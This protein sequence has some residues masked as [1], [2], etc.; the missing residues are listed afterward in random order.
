MAEVTDLAGETSQ[1]QT[2]A[3]DAAA[4]PRRAA[5]LD[6]V[7][8][9]ELPGQPAISPDG[10]R[11]IYVLRTADSGADAE[12]SSL[13]QVPAGGG[14]PARLTRGPADTAPA[15][16]P[17]GSQVAFLRGGDAPAQVW[18]LPA[19]AGE[20][21]QLTELP[22]GAGAPR[23]SPDGS[24]IAFTAPTAPGA[25][26]TGQENKTAPAVIDRLGYKADGAGL[27]AGLRSHLHVADVATGQVRQVTSGDWHAGQ[28]EWSPDGRQ[29]AFAA[30]R[31]EDWDLSLTSAAYVVDA[32]AAGAEPRL[33]GDSSGTVGSVTWE[34]SGEALLV[35][36]GEARAG[37]ARLR[38]VPLDGAEAA[39]LATDLDRNVMPGA[40]GYPGGQPAFTG[41]GQTILFCARNRGCTSLYATTVSG[42][43]AA[44]V[45]A[46]PGQVVAGLSVAPGAGRAAVVLAGPASFGE[47]AV[48]D[49]PAG[50]GQ[51]QDGAGLRVLTGHTRRALPD[52]RLLEATER[53]FTI[54]D[55][56]RVHGWLL[57]D[58][59]APLPA[60]LLLD[61]HGGPHNA[62]NPAADHGHLYQQVLAA[63]GFAVLTV[64]PRGSDGYGE[65]FY[66]AAVGAWGHGDERDFLEPVD[67]L[68]AEG[69][70]DPYRLAVTGYSY[71]G[72]MTCHLTTRTTRFSAAVAGGAVCDLASMAGTSDVGHGLA[73]TEL[74][75][76][77]QQ[78]RDQ[79]A[80]QSPIERAGQVT[81]PTLLLHG[82]DDDRCPRGQAEQWFTA[83]RERRVPTRLVLYP[84]A[85]HLFILEGRP[86]HRA[87]YGRRL[88]GWVCEHTQPRQ[89]ARAAAPDG[90][91]VPV[92]LDQAHWAERLSLLAERHSVPGAVL[93]ILRM[94]PG[95]GDEQVLAASGVLSTATGVEVTT[96]SLF[97]IGSIT[98]VWTATL[99]M[100]F[101]DEG[102][103]DLDAPLEAVLPGL[104]LPGTGLARRLTVRHLLTHTSGIDGDL[105]ADTGRGDDCVQKYVALLADA[106]INHPPGATLSYCNSGY[107]LAGRIAEVLGGASWD[108]VLRKRLCVPLGLTRT[109]T[110][111]EEALLGRAAVGHVSEDG[112]APHPAPVWVLPRSAGPAGLICTT[113]ADVLGFARLHLAGGRAPDGT[114]LLSPGAAEAMQA[115]QADM[116][117]P[118][119]LGDSWGLGWIRFGWDGHRLA[120]HDGGTIGQ[121]AYLRLLPGQGLAVTLLTNGGHP[122]DLYQDLFREIFAEVAGVSMPA[123]LAPPDDPPPVDLARYTGRYERTSVRTDVFERDGA[124]VLRSTPTGEIAELTGRTAH[125]FGLVPVAEDLFVMRDEDQQTWTPVV[126]YALAD[127][128]PYLHYGVRAQPRIG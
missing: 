71:G 63:R 77:P 104:R 120:G 38:R 3:G 24:Q 18:L 4:S 27:L 51:G 66:T 53:E 34:P 106:K 90:H 44:A 28:P 52:V 19:T 95:G 80:A 81:T 36:A 84:G 103:L 9:L 119:T 127:G 128:T 99:L 25:D 59:A 116:P 12:H 124:L 1:Q 97:Q 47:V 17:D 45:L 102:R 82:A 14:D 58:P 26:A 123:P 2:P 75:G 96:D 88:I 16:S 76:T 125:E 78:N 94:H 43:A 32:A 100:Q 33:A 37:H 67:E 118:H 68:V 35:V 21:R 15:W 121:S 60:P 42:G 111:P 73:V 98:K 57:R 30:A 92:P 10:T 13:W 89:P 61:I 65:S 114:Q 40:P 122:R 54:S 22:L 46:G 109:C 74:G 112:E 23:W 62:W 49:L 29:L 20:P 107:I 108:E 50:L 70:A 85:S 126:F 86:S 79:V 6:D 115:R 105:F 101:A 87:D 56:T 7:Y 8:A 113:A 117:D 41:D 5:R 39:G 69:I 55:G 83:L 64:N 31:G 11:V 48:I 72:F 91:R 110:L 93:G